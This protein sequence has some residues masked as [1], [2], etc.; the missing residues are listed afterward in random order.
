M[1]VEI[2]VRFHQNGMTPAV[3]PLV[4]TFLLPILTVHQPYFIVITAIAL[5]ITI[6]IASVS[7]RS[8]AFQE[9]IPNQQ[10]NQLLHQETI[11]QFAERVVFTAA[12]E[13]K[14]INQTGDLQTHL[15]RNF[16]LAQLT[17]MLMSNTTQLQILLAK[18]TLA[19]VL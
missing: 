19:I 11:V 10:V 5:T 17:V 3:L 18:A 13:I 6:T 1:Q 9:A 7:R 15:A 12:G 8:V 4:W 14:L 2:D 16:T